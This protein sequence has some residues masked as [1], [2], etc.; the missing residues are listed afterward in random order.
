MFPIWTSPCLS[1]VESLALKKRD[2]A[3]HSELDADEAEGRMHGVHEVEVKRRHGAAAAKRHAEI[4]LV[5]EGE[6]VDVTGGEDHPVYGRPDHELTLALAVAQPAIGAQSGAE[7]HVRHGLSLVR[8][9]RR[10][11]LLEHIDPLGHAAELA[12]DVD[13]GGAP[14][15]DEDRGLTKLIGVVIVAR[16]DERAPAI[17]SEPLGLAWDGRHVRLLVVPIGHEHG[18]ESLGRLGS[19][20]PPCDFPFPALASVTTRARHT[21]DGCLEL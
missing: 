20:A 5:E 7:R 11:L 8:Q 9:W 17:C 6:G 3:R 12:R 10:A 19:V 18:V 13:A 4:F 1:Q 15:D 14:P 16:V 21:R 2:W